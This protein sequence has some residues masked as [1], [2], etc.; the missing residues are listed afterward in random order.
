MNTKNHEIKKGLF[1]ILI[2]NLRKKKDEKYKI[3]KT[4]SHV[5]CRQKGTN[6]K[7]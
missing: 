4:D 3:Q 5:I 2:R 6:N 7:S 1:K